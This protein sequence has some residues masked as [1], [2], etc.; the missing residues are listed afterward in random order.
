M[1]MAPEPSLPR[2]GLIQ[3]GLTEFAA[4][5]LRKNSNPYFAAACTSRN[6]LC[7]ER[8]SLAGIAGRG[9]ER[10]ETPS[11]KGLCLLRKKGICLLR[12]VWYNGE[13][14]PMEEAV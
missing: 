3:G 5:R 2:R 12:R 7:A 14:I 11:A 6:I 1:T 4:R 8:T 9:A 13:K 10:S